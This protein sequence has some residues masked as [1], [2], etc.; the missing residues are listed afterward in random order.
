MKEKPSL[1][2]TEYAILFRASLFSSSYRALI[3][4]TIATFN[5]HMRRAARNGSSWK[6]E[7]T[8]EKTGDHGEGPSRCRQYDSRKSTF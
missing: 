4:I 2:N 7:D 6:I 5:S 8:D 1:Q 3:D